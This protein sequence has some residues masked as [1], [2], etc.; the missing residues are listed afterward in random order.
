MRILSPGIITKEEDVFI[1]SIKSTFNSTKIEKVIKDQ[2]NLS[3]ISRADC[4][5][6]DMT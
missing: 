6:G 5:E 2:Y 3:S 1:T 4:K